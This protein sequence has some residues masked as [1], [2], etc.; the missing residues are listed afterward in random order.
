MIKLL[1]AGLRRY[2]KSAVF[3]LGIVATVIC[4]VV[5]GS[6]ATKYLDD[7][8]ITF[9]FFIFAIVAVWHIGRENDEGI[10]RNKISTGHTKGKI[11]LSELILGTVMCSLMFLIHSAIFA[12]FNS[13]V[14]TVVTSDVLI[15]LFIDF[16]LVN[17]AINTICIFFAALMPHRAIS[18]I[19]TIL[20]IFCVSEFL[21]PEIDS[22]LSQ[23][24]YIYEYD[25][26]EV[27]FTDP[28]GHLGV[29]EEAIPGTER[30]YENPKY[31]SGISRNFLE[32]FY[33]SLPW[34][35]LTNAYDTIHPYLGLSYKFTYVENPYGHPLESKDSFSITEEQ[36]QM[37]TEGIVWSAGLFVVISALGYLGFRRREF[38]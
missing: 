28:F 38:K 33:K 27:T 7:F 34:A 32:A 26:E 1:H 11:F 15:K 20:L 35:H 36:D 24:E 25:Y 2:L 21:A 12:I 37:L 3:W 30:K 23:D 8:F 10:L 9:Q 14:F 16:F 22:M 17:I 29:Q 13:Y 5:T 18:A 6:E 31:I 4:G 19:V